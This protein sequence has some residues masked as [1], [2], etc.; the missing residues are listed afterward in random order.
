MTALCFALM[1]CALIGLLC[2]STIGSRKR[3]GDN[4]LQ[5]PKR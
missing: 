5:S 1:G 4:G 3:A 2:T